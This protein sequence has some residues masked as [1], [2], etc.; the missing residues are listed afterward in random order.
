MEIKKEQ[1]AIVIMK[2]SN[3]CNFGFTIMDGNFCSLYPIKDDVFSLSSVVS[4][5]FN[6][7][8]PH[9]FEIK[10]ILEKIVF[11]NEKFFFFNKRQIIDYYFGIK[12]KI[13]NDLDDQRETYVFKEGDLISVFAG[14]VSTVMHSAKEVESLIL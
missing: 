5:P 11:D 14:K 7:D 2:D 8:M 12:T 10:S 4:T 9:N 13:K 3:Y 1:C 6:K